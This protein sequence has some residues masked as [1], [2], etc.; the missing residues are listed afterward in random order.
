MLRG[1][2]AKV[3]FE[4][5]GF[6]RACRTLGAEVA[7]VPYWGGPLNSPLPLLVTVHDL[8]PLLLPEYRGG[9]LARIYTGLVAA[10]ARGAANILTD[11]EASRQDVIQRLSIPEEQV[12]TVHLAAGPGVHS[13]GRRQP[14]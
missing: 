4:Q 11:S 3:W 8:I 5:V 1:Q 7:H 2:L 9:P 6:P 13:S 12:H 10:S 14:G